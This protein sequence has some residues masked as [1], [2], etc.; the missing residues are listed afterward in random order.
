VKEERTMSG[1]T[2]ATAQLSDA[3]VRLGIELRVAPPGIRPIDPGMTLAGPAR[4][5]R[6]YGSVDIFFEAIEAANDGEVLIID[7]GGRSDEGCIGDLTALEARAAGLSGLVVWGFH[8]DDREL[9]AIGW[10]VFSYGTL[11]VGPLRVD[12]REPEALVSACL[13]DVT[14]TA[15][16]W[17]FGDSDGVLVIPSS[18]VDEATEVAQGIA[19]TERR[20]AARIIAGES[21][22]DQLRFGEYLERRAADDTYAFRDHVR[23]IGGAIEE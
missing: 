13:G 20:Q 5:V 11:S 12:A 22:R 8:R 18:R 6:H 15:D 7:N 19:A 1:P 16:D 17:V 23:S 9:R 14:V 21:L 2:V 10:P 4:P 3:C